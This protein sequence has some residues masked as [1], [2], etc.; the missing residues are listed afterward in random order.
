MKP[1]YGE[2][3]NIL[4]IKENLGDK[5]FN[6]VNLIL[7]G[8][9][10]LIVL[11][12]LYFVIIASISNPDLVNTG[13]VIFYPKDITLMGYIRIFND[14][15][16]L[17][18]Y[19]NTIFYAVSGTSINLFVTLTCAYALSKK[20]LR[21]RNFFTFLFSFTMFFSGGLIPTYI[22]IKNLN[23][24]NTVWALII[25]SAV[26]M[27][28]V[29]V[30]RTFFMNSVPAELEES[31]YMDG[32]NTTYTFIKIVLPLTKALVAVLALFYGVAHWN[33]FF[34]AMIYISN[35]KLFPLQ[36]ILREIL[37]KNEYKAS[38]MDMVADDDV[39]SM[40]VKI[41]SMIKYGVII[42]SSLPVLIAYPFLQK[43]F[44]AG[45]M[46]GAIKG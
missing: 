39:L 5:I 24:T 38:M 17:R 1:A 21:F 6:I 8:L 18:G 15:E 34:D 45:I 36:L 40:Q 19:R 27:Y 13:K 4:V 14:G 29:I 44:T 10:V 35:R 32:C 33:A 43:Y 7:L 26:S 9:F 12:P 30:A 3:V 20:W 25:P 46:M 16:I 42:I 28:N 41:A 31:A 23:M 2:G 22:L 11:Y 37:I